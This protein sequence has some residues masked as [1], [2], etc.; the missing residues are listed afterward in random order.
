M[1]NSFRPPGLALVACATALATAPVAHARPV[2]AELRVEAGKPVLPGYV[3]AT[4]STR[5]QT[6]RR[7]GC[8]GSGGTKTISGPSALG[9]LQSAARSAGALRPVSI[10]DKYD[11]GLLLCGIGNVFAAADGS[12]YWLYKVNHRLPE[13]GG[14]H[15]A[16]KGGEQVLWY[17][18]DPPRGIDSGTAPDF[19]AAELELVAPARARPAR[20]FAVQ[21]YEYDAE[22]RRKPAADVLVLGAGGQR[23]DAR[24][25]ARILAGREGWLRLRAVRG[26]D[27]PAAP[28]N[29]C[30]R[31][32]LARCPAVRGERIFGTDAADRL[33]GTR[34][35]DVVY[36]G[37]GND[38]IDVRGGGRDRVH[39]GSGRDL[40]RLGRGD[41]AARD[42]ERVRR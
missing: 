33:R 37:G 32:V 34:G 15:F 28:V 9:I 18:V 4:D 31:R 3:Y 29:V 17:F 19:S 41:R 35:A 6:D 10:S 12:S 30:L 38:V 27:V 23:T 21:A 22:G 2:T 1:Q 20:R 5:F 8:D 7:P 42:C 11:F 25:R 24:G 13:V 39:C 40:A 36:G 14:D 16:L 26:R